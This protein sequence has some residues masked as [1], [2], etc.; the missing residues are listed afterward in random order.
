M[1]ISDL[2][3][4]KR[5]FMMHKIMQGY[6]TGTEIIASVQKY[7]KKKDFKAVQLA[8]VKGNPQAEH[9]WLKNGIQ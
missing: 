8:C 9:F 2:F 6:G 4:P 3:H 1:G 5:I 7:L